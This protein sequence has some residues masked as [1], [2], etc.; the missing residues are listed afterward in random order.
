MERTF[1]AGILMSA[2]L[3]YECWGSREKIEMSGE[4]FHGA[5]GAALKVEYELDAGKK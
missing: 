3:S 4:Q 5:F 1:H 2:Q